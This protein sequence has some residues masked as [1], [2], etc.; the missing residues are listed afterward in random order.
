[1]RK[2]TLVLY[3]LCCTLAMQAQM[4]WHEA[5]VNGMLIDFYSDAQ[6]IGVRFAIEPDSMTIGDVE[7]YA[8]DSEGRL[9]NTPMQSIMPRLE[10]QQI[11]SHIILKIS[12]TTTSTVWAMSFTSICHSVA[13]CHTWR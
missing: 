5:S 8:T 3:L 6:E 2:Y 11:H 4:V 7:L 9:C 1:M 12:P 10:S 13:D